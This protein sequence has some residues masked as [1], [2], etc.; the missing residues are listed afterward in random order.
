MPLPRSGAPSPGQPLQV[1]VREV[2]GSAAFATTGAN[3]TN[4]SISN[5]NRSF[6]NGDQKRIATPNIQF[7]PGMR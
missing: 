3:P 7:R 4:T 2:G 6:I 1:G 5:A